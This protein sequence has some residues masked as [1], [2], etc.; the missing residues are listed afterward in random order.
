MPAFNSEAFIER[1]IQSVISQ[2]LSNWEL[3]IVDDKSEDNTCDV[4]KK[5]LDKDKRINL[6]E[7]DING[8]PAKAR[9]MGIEIAR[10]RYIAFI[11]SDDSW[12]P[13]KLERQYKVFSETGCTICFSSYK[14]IHDNDKKNELVIAKKNLN[15]IDMHWMNYIGCSTAIYDTH[16]CGVKFLPLI[17]Y[18]EDY[19]LWLSILKN[20]KSF[21]VGI[22]EPL[23]N[24]YVR[25]NSESQ[26][27]YRAAI[28]H[29]KAL[30]YHGRPS[31]L[32]KIINFCYYAGHHSAK[33]ILNKFK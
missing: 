31:I 5:Y 13:E 6:V 2:T 15:Y 28:G 12:E 26:E 23:V 24:Y 9:N 8:G 29:W 30:L 17:R 10:E 20:K 18:A 7:V 27:K 4:V 19:S 3:I 16:K 14:K 11:D 22:Q 25:S 21:A 32:I 33:I 1:A